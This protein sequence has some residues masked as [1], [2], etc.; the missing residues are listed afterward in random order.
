V[1]INGVPILIQSKDTEEIIRT[2]AAIAPT[3][4]A[5]KIET[6]RPPSASRSRIAWRDARHPCDAR[7]P[8]RHGRRRPG[9]AAE[10]EQSTS[11]LQVKNDTS[12]WWAG[13]AGIGISKLLM[14]SGSARCSAPTSIRRAGDLR[15]GSAQARHA[16]EIMV[17]AD[18]VICTTGVPG[19]IKKEM[20]RKGR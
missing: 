18:I 10:R 6:S 16:S 12:E 17:S 8:A 19:L 2:V 14:P 4:G 5:I 9:R 20:I 15:E 3:F 1:G 7:R 13:A 11:G